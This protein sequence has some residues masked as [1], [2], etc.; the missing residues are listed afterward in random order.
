M[1]A[2]QRVAASFGGGATLDVNGELTPPSYTI[3]GTG[4]NN[5]GSA[6]AALDSALNTI[7]PSN[8]VHVNSSGPAANASGADAIALGS[9]AQA[10]Q[11]GSIAI[12]LN[13]SSTGTNAIAIGTGSIA[14]GSVAVGA[15][16]TASTTAATGAFGRDGSHGDRRQ[17]RRTRDQRD[18]DGGELGCDRLGLDQ[19]RRQHGFVRLGPGTNGG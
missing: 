12:G 18:G 1:T 9:N 17:R 16:A 8:Y 6:F 7:S 13:S 5:V 3:Q 4:Y 14:T 15:G 10:T 19:R 11:S 2:N